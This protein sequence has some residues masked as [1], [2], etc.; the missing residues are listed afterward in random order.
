[1]IKLLIA[2]LISLLLTSCMAIPKKAVRIEDR[3]WIENDY[4]R[5]LKSIT[6][7]FTIERILTRFDHTQILIAGKNNNK[8]VILLHAMG[9]NLTSWGP[10]IEALSQYFKVIAIDVIG[11]QGRSIARRDYP[12]SITEYAL[13]LNDIIDKHQLENVTIV[14]CSMGGWIAHGYAIEYPEKVQHLVL[15]SPAAGIPQKTK[16]MRILLKM[17]FTN[18][19]TKLKEASRELLG[20]YRASEDWLDYMAKTSKDP[21]SAKLGMPTEFSDEQLAKTVGKVLLLIGEGEYI[22]KSTDDVVKR[23]KKTI[24]NITVKIIPEAGHLGAW[25]N[26]DFVNTEIISFIERE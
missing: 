10:S 2:R 5:R 19:E 9:L 15:I 4:D 17:L 22:Y 8:V 21:K 13:W 16:W 1:M 26:P 18:D 11:D 20:P 7:P 23:A 24:P 3:L 12:E 6:V 14:G 25:D